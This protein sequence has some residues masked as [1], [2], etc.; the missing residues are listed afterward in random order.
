MLA[1]LWRER[2]RP[3][4]GS[5]D[6]VRAWGKRSLL[7]RVCIQQWIIHFKLKRNGANIHP[8]AFLSSTLGFEGKYDFLTV[9][10]ESF[11]G[12][13]HIALH[14]RVNVAGRVCINDGV[15]LLTASHD[16]SDS[17]WPTITSP[18]VI[19]DYVWI[20]TNAIILPGVCIGRGAVVGAGAVVSKNVVPGS[21]VVGNPAR[22][23][24]TTRNDVLDYSPTDRVAL[25]SAWK[26]C[27]R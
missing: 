24:G 1:K 15:K 8:G 19:S 7:F 26:R 2:D 25:F 20:A 21:I 4:W 16:V 22:P 18:I 12:R 3:R 11:I 6:W 9:G 5:H 17:G 23:V 27:Q 14:D 13:V 10:N